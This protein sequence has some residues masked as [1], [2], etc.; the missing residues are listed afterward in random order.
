MTGT[1]MSRRTSTGIPYYRVV[2]A[3][4]YLQFGGN[5]HP[6]YKPFGSFVYFRG[7]KYAL[8]FS[9]MPVLPKAYMIDYDAISILDFLQEIAEATNHELFFSLLPIVNNTATA[10]FSK[11]C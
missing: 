6:E 1:G 8:D 5:V 2:Q 7:L 3:L 10:S 4:N 9:G 11:S